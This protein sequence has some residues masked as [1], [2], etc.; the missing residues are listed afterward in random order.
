MPSRNMLFAVFGKQM[1]SGR[2]F[3]IVM[4]ISTIVHSISPALFGVIADQWGLRAAVRVFTLPVILGCISA[5]A[6]AR[7]IKNQ[8][9]AFVSS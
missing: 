7:S 2:V 6:F 9:D 8:K 1:G 5:V 3:G 4:A